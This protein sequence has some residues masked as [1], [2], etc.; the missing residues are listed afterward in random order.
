MLC[1][2]KLDCYDC[3]KELLENE[4]KILEFLD[5]LPEVVKMKKISKPFVIVYN[6]NDD[7]WGLSGFVFIAESHISIHSY[8][9]KRFALVDLFSCKEFDS[10][11]AVEYCESFFKTKNIEKKLEIRGSRVGL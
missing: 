5:S 8:P 7:K 9:E 2:L 4:G 6:S 11:E 1:H 3:D 10:K